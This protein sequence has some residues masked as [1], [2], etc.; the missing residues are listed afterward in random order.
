MLGG[1]IFKNYSINSTTIIDAKL[2]TSISLIICVSPYI[3]YFLRNSLHI[4]YFEKRLKASIKEIELFKLTYLNN[5]YLNKQEKNTTSYLPEPDVFEVSSDKKSVDFSTE[6]KQKSRE[7]EGLKVKQIVVYF[8][9]LLSFFIFTYS[10]FDFIKVYFEESF[11]KWAE[12]SVVF[13]GIIISSIFTVLLRVIVP[14]FTKKDIRLDIRKAE[15]ELYQR[16]QKNIDAVL[17][18]TS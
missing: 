17:D 3:L 4:L 7:L 10:L 13:L 15:N 9:F 12:I 14:L 6:L 11:G 18:K 16:F 1:V 5:D 2:I 8:L